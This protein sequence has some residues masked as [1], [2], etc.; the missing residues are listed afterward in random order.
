MIR[1]LILRL[2]Y[3]K[4]VASSIRT[5]RYSDNEHDRR[6]ALY[7]LSKQDGITPTFIRRRIYKY[8]YIEEIE[9]YENTSYRC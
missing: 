3:G 5:L 1:S 8:L 9:M 6:Y 4:D 2:R 7:T